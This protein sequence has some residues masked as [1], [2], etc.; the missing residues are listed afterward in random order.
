MTWNEAFCAHLERH[1]LKPQQ[2]ALKHRFSP[3]KVH[4]WTKGSIPRAKMRERIERITKGDV[5]AALASPA[6]SG[7]TMPADDGTGTDG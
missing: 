2:F 5:P 4:Y 7:H 3:S 6:E 1:G